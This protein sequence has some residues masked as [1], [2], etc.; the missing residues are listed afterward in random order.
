MAA[1]KK[2]GTAGEDDLLLASIAHI[3][4]LFIPVVVPL[5]IWVTAKRSSRYRIL[6][7]K[8]ATVYQLTV[9]AVVLALMAASTL[10]SPL[11]C[12]GAPTFIF[13][14]VV[15]FGAV[16][17]GFYGGYQA[18]LGRPFSYRYVN[19]LVDGNAQAP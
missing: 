7:A 8:Q 18:Y 16:V 3:G 6:Q 10:L 12:L 1:T 9:V 17:Y 4:G 15:G 5:L 13:A 2:T 19:Q 14:L 11:V